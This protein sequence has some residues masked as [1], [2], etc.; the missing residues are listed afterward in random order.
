[1]NKAVYIESSRRVQDARHL[2]N[3]IRNERSECHV[4]LLRFRAYG[5]VRKKIT[6][7]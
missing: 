6:K 1:M 7:Q 5:T 4:G 2:S 3:P